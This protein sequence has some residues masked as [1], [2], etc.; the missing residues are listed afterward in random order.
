MSSGPSYDIMRL[1]HTPKRASMCNYYTPWIFY[2]L[3]NLIFFLFATENCTAQKLKLIHVL[4]DACELPACGLVSPSKLLHV[5]YGHNNEIIKE[6][7]NIQAIQNTLMPLFGGKSNQ[8]TLAGPRGYQG[9]APPPRECNSC[10]FHTV[11]GENW[12]K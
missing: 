10:H 5:M 2:L 8:L 12:P 7:G 9:Y 6:A 11:S 3:L 4:V 1:L